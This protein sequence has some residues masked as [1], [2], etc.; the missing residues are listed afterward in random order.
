MNILLTM[1]ISYYEYFI[2]KKLNKLLQM[3]VTMRLN[4]SFKQM[5]MHG[6]PALSCKSSCTL[7]VR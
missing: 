6:F 1:N 2:I 3:C 7:N 5:Q 4:D